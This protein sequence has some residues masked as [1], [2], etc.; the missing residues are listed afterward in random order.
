VT[1]AFEPDDAYVQRVMAM[2]GHMVDVDAEGDP[3]DP[4]VLAQ[5]L[6]LMDDGMDVRIVTEDALDHEPL[7]IAMTT[8]CDR[9]DIP[10]CRL[11]DFLSHLGF[12]MKPKR[13][14]GAP[15]DA[16]ESNNNG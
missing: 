13:A 12:A 6:S 4:Y 9:M 15:D 11:A 3:G 7:R 16:D 10:Y 2:A 14:E 8:G 1:A 5:A